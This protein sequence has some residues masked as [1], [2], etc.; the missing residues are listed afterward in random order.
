ML[1]E[2][3]WDALGDRLLH[4]DFSRVGRGESAVV[5]LAIELRGAAPGTK[6]GGVVEHALREVE[7][8]CP[9]MSIPEKIQVSIN[10]LQLDGVI[11]AADIPLPSGATLVTDPATQVAICVEPTI[12]DE[13]ELAAGATGAEPEVIGGKPEDG[14]GGE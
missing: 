1:K 14:E 9:V 2:L 10:E 13:E 6:M 8:D 7:I 5:S 4:V 11:T 12:H 3:Q